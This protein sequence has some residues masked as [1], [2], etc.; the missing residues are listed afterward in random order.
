MK[1]LLVR[2]GCLVVLVVCTTG[3]GGAFA[4]ASGQFP[5]SIYPPPVHAHSGAAF[6]ACANPS[7]LER[8][9]AAATKLAVQVAMRY[10]HV[11][12]AAD[13]TH[14]DRSFWPMLRGYWR[15]SK[16]GAWLARLQ[17]VRATQLGGPNMVWSGV[18]RYYCGPK[19][20]T[21]SL[22][23]VV[24]IRHLQRCADCNGVDELFIDRRGVPLVYMV[25]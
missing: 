6:S 21:D 9:D 10:G 20:L 7:G 15:L 24:T 8:F 19:L 25:H 12:L 18:V 13:R 23:V 5:G 1:R 22:D 2:H 14:S 3:A 11:S 16:H 17:V 4:T